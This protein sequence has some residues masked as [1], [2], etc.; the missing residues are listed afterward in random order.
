[1]K[2]LDEYSRFL[3]RKRLVAPPCGISEPKPL[4]SRLF[5]FQRDITAWALRRGRAAIWA[6]CGLG[7]SWMAIEWARWVAA[8]TMRP[9]LIL[10]PLAVA[11]Q[12]VDE[13]TKLLGAHSV[14]QC[15]TAVDLDPGINVT[16]YERLH[17]FDPSAFGG[18]VLDE[19]SILKDYTSATRNALIEAFA[20]TP[21]KLAC[22]ATP[23]PND[24]VELGNHAE[25]L[26]VMSRTEMLSM[27]FVHDGG[28]TQDWRLK[29]HAEADFWRWVC[30]WAVSMRKP[31][32]LGYANEGYDLPPLNVHEH[33]VGELDAVLGMMREARTLDAQRAARRASLGARV[34]KAAELVNGTGG[35]WLLWCDL[36]DESKALAK[37]CDG[38]VEVTGSDSP[39]EKEASLRMFAEG[40]ARVLVTKPS[41]C[42]HGVNLQRCHQSAFV[43]LSHC[44]DAETELL[45]RR[46]WLTFD[47]V[48]TDD[49]VATVSPE[50]MGLEWQKPSEVIWSDYSGEM[51]RFGRERN[52]DLLVTP[53]HRLFVQRCPIRFP[54]DLGAWKL[55]PAEDIAGRFRRQEYRMRSAPAFASG[56]QPESVDLPI[57]DN[58][59]LGHK[60]RLLDEIP[61]ETYLRIAGWYISEGHCRPLD[62][63][64]AGQTVIC[65]TDVHPENRREI[66]S[67]LE[68]IGLPVNSKTKDITVY[69]KQLASN[70]IENFGHLSANKRIPRWVKDLDSELLK[71]LRDTML[72]GDGL[73]RD[74]SPRGYRTTSA[75]L[76]DDFQ[77]I[78]LA[79]GIR[80]T[81]R[82]RG[83]VGVNPR[84]LTYDVCLAWENVTPSIHRA[85]ETVTYSGK[86]GC[87][88]VPNHT[89]VVRRRGTPVVSGNS[90]EA[91]YQAIRR[92]WRFGQ[93]KDVDCHIIT[94][95]E[96]GAVL[97]NLKRKQR[98]AEVMAEGMIAHMA[99][100]SSAEIR[101][102]ERTF[103]GYEPR[104]P[105]TVPRWLKE[106]S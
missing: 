49:E 67:L 100:I 22:T 90:F 57:P 54:S 11:R 76:A 6:D 16:N 5:P 32:D 80:A 102:T 99:E 86:I 106:A 105:M 92:N 1:M 58:F 4:S 55:L 14:K 21:F 104:R 77:E 43:G 35:Q 38:A 95:A 98:D 44:Y 10:T 8:H 46:G 29:G 84:N 36:N 60:A 24:H 85:P 64:H 51:L 30:S 97:A 45:T 59:R 53:N 82:C 33:I 65:Q 25:F 39:E 63:E 34:A 89:V 87:V 9:V 66:I 42:G 12:F 74:G 72:K 81:V 69:S 61:T 17:H 83:L 48:T 40:E 20:S 31:S 56:K 78:C 2:A 88:V 23:A 79:T 75:Q 27:F 37:A 13:G 26:G 47:R 68:S 94:S 62:T 71:I 3:D 103:T 73:H 50:T 15:K 52:F 101:A 18:V 70:L 41:I 91:W 28:S 19:S 7:K 96:E 93:T